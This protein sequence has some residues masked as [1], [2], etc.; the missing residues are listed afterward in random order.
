MLKQLTSNT[1]NIL[2]TGVFILFVILPVIFTSSTVESFEFPKTIFL[3]VCA[4][5]LV[6]WLFILKKG[7]KC[8]VPLPIIAFLG[9]Y[10]LA[11]LLSSHFYTSLWGYYSRFNGGFYSIICFFFVFYVIVNTFSKKDL[12]VLK[13]LVVICSL[14]V[15]VYGVMQHFQF[16]LGVPTSEITRVYSTLGQ[17][18]WLGAYLAGMCML[19]FGYIT[20]AKNKS[21]I[22]YAILFIFN[23]AGLWFTFS[24]SSII[25]FV[26][27][28][29]YWIF[30]IKTTNFKRL[31][32]VATF[33][34]VITILQPGIWAQ[35]IED[36][37]KSI[38]VINKAYAQTKVT[39]NFALSDSGEIR[40]GIWKGTLNIVFSSPKN[41]IIGTG[42]ETFPYEFQKVRPAELNYSSEWDYILNK[43]HNYYLEILSTTGVLGLASYLWLL[44]WILVKTPKKLHPFYIVIMVTNFFSWPT[45]V[46]NLLF[47]GF[48]AYAHNLYDAENTEALNDN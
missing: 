11:T 7:K 43:P 15:S 2:K 10:G 46:I 1:E 34:A 30:V 26:A 5:T 35:R 40:K 32:L 8:K 17:P 36:A 38:G 22:N 28:L 14:P 24:V 31:A 23:F 20:T 27:G 29:G 39:Q 25:G 37:V 42:P 9:I 45:S 44:I 3:Y 48:A 16:N 4:S 47:W 13:K 21:W 6:I 41:L 33:C 19:T 18:N 12:S